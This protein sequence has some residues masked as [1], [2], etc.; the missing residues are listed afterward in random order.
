MWLFCEFGITQKRN[1]EL[2]VVLQQ[3]LSQKEDVS[4]ALINSQQDEIER[5]SRDLAVQ[6][7]HCI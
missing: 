1:A 2:K 7:V 6:Q 3:Q 4:S 5:L